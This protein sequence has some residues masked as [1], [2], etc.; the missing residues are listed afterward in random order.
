MNS[1]LIQIDTVAPTV[2]LTAPAANAIL[3]GI[4]NLTANAADNVAVGH[5]DFL[6]DGVVVG[7]AAASPYGFAWSSTSVADGLHTV[8]ARAVDTAGNQATTSAISVHVA[9]VNL[10]KNASLEAAS[11][12]APTCW[13]L[14]G[15]G[16]NTFAWSRTPDAHS[17]SFGESLNVTSYTS[18]DRKLVNTQDAGA[19]APAVTAG[20][21]YT[22]TAWYKSTVHRPLLR[23][24]P[25]VHGQLGVL[26]AVVRQGG[27]VHVDAG[28][29]HHPGDPGRRH[30]HLDRPGHH[31]H[32]HAHDGRLRALHE[33]TP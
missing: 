33:L 13:A 6:V 31:V 19:C 27:D 1:R 23:L 20:R 32:R 29:L 22:M 18:G 8:S 26:D 21:T 14:G 16:T 25:H 15:Y 11:G 7:Q 30:E 5:V 24:L 4:V 9:N 10:L 28:E 2:S 12:S 3:S 17:G